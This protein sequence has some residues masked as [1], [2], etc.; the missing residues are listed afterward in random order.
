MLDKIRN[1]YGWGRLLSRFLLFVKK[2]GKEVFMYLGELHAEQYFS[3]QS[4]MLKHRFK[5]RGVTK[6]IILVSLILIN[7]KL[8]MS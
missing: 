5:M 6:D 7:R 4:W 8:A 3:I 2:H 1:P